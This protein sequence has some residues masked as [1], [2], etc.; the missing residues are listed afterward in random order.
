MSVT[1]GAGIVLFASL[2]LM[3]LSMSRAESNGTL[4]VVGQGQVSAEPNMATVSLSVSSTNDTASDARER[5]AELTKATLT[6]IRGIS[7]INRTSDIKTTDINVNPQMVY[8]SQ[9]GESTIT[10]YTFSQNLQVTVRDLS[11]D[12]LSSVIDSAV[13][14]GGNA[15][16]IT[17]VTLSLSPTA[18]KAALDAARRAAVSDARDTARLLASAAEVTLGRPQRIEDSNST[19]AMPIA[20]AAAGAM[21]RNAKDTETPVELGTLQVQ[22]TVS[23]TYAVE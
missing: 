13:R 10:G 7:G 9:T 17:S 16:Q 14:A 15:L 6:S 3:G 1:R 23:I 22:A 8:N 2:T 19:P 5:A 21:A 20:Y 11:S 4:F 18:R 12:L